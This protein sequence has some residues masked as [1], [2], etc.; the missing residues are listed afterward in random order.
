MSKYDIAIVYRIYP[1]VSKVPPIFSDD[2]FKLSE[3]CLSSF[4]EALNGINFKLYVILDHCPGSYKNLFEKYF[5]DDEVEYYEIPHTGNAGTFGMQMDILLEQDEA[6][7][8]YFAEDDYFYLPDAFRKMLDFMNSDVKPD[9]VTPFDHL[10]YYRLKLHDYNYKTLASA[11]HQWREAATTCMT[12]MTRKSTLA[13]TEK[14]FRTY[15]K[16]NY[17]ASLWMS[18]TKIN[19]SNP[20]YLS[21]IMSEGNL[22]TRILVKLFSQG[23][24]QLVLGKKYRLF[25]PKPS[26]ATHMD[27]VCLAPDID[28]NSEFE[29]KLKKNNFYDL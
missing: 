20:L 21:K 10:D 25:A 6:E 14:V 5:S 24:M 18:L 7:I 11:G 1:E 2:K 22:Y 8:V 23:F 9:F 26:L 4:R 15:T 12:F 3:L 13:A 17:D 19:V 27:S 29:N 16:N 28:W